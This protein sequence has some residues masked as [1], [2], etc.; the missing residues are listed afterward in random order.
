MSKH[1]KLDILE[2]NIGIIFYVKG[3]KFLHR[4]N[5]PARIDVTGYMEYCIDNYTHREDGPAII[6]YLSNSIGYWVFGC[7]YIEKEYYKKIA[8]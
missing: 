6:D 4:E 3:T 8:K 1:K 7:V 5:G 2:D